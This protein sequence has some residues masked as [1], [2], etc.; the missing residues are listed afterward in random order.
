MI[1][2]REIFQREH[3][4]LIVT[5]R[6]TAVSYQY[7]GMISNEGIPG[8]IGWYGKDFRLLSCTKQLLMLRACDRGVGRTP[9]SIAYNETVRFAV[10]GKDGI[11]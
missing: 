5:F 9:K 2:S 11:Y 1:R 8:L 10:H 6:C 4:L 3:P 7:S